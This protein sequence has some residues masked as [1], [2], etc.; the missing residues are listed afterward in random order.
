GARQLLDPQDSL[1]PAL[2]PAPPPLHAS[3]HADL[4]L[5]AQP[6]RAL[7]R[8]A[9]DEVDQARDTPLR[10]RPRRLDPH[11]D[12]QLERRPETVPL[13]QDRRRD[14]PKPRRLLPAD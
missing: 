4:Q 2:A 3:F 14:P 11:L 5:L 7:V 12:H 1:D 10:S 8:R 6:R 13:A 9:N